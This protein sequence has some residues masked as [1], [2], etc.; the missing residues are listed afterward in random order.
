MTSNMRYLSLCLVIIVPGLDNQLIDIC[1][2]FRVLWIIREIAA[3]RSV[4]Y[5]DGFEEFQRLEFMGDIRTSNA[6]LDG[7][8]CILAYL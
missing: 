7:K 2:N 6:E 3:M 4:R 8:D 5:A 1:V